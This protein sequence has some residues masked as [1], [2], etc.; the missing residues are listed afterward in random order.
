MANLRGKQVLITEVAKVYTERQFADAYISEPDIQDKEYVYMSATQVRGELRGG[1]R[2][3]L[4]PEGSVAVIPES[5]SAGYLSFILNSLPGQTF[6]YGMKFNQK[7]K[8]AITK[9]LVSTIVLYEVSEENEGAYTVA[10]TVRNATYERYTKDRSNETW[11]MMY[12]LMS[13]FC[14]IMALEL[15][16]HPLFEQ[17]G[18]LIMENWKKVLSEPAQE[19]SVNIFN[20]LIQS[21]HPLRN[22]IMKAHMV[23][24]EIV[25][26]LKSDS[27]GLENQ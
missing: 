11:Q 26:Y 18:V 1:V 25:D 21:D 19:A 24:N 10:D 4:L 6:L 20:A 12:A 16:A 8:T 3:G 27:N 13:D 5:C 14:N 2:K 15:Y 22:A 9:K 7:L 23:A 17:K